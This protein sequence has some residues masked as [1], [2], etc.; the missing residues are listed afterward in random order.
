M[1]SVHFMAALL[2]AV[3]LL[4]A[5]IAR[6]EDRLN[7]VA[8]EN[9]YGDLARQIGGSH[10]AVTSILNNPDEDP[11]LFEASPSTA[12]A[13]PTRRSS[14]TTAPT[15]IRGWTSCSRHRS[16]RDRTTIVV[17][18][19]V[20]KKSGDNPH[21]WYDPATMPAVAKALAADLS[22]ARSRQRGDYDARLATFL[23]SLKAIDNESP[24]QQHYAGT[25]VTA[26]EPVFGY[27]AEALGFKM[28]NE[29]F[30]LAVMNDT[31]PSAADIAAFEKEP[32]G[33]RGQ[34]LDLQSARL[35]TSATK[36]L[37]ELAK[38]RQGHRHRRHRDR[39]RRPDLSRLVQRPARRAVERA[40][41]RTH[42]RRRIRAGDADARA[43]AAFFPTSPFPLRDGEFVGLLGPTAPAR[44]R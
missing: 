12:R 1:R 19:L 34:V 3:P 8:A 11:H 23:A 17:A 4:T 41:D 13:M 40:A 25:P 33:R 27:M 2:V 28:L 14:S 24:G 16:G 15:T 39:A 10:V 32:E 21:L 35:P 22:Q 37:L 6:A 36:R 38:A 42:E 31:E 5:N 9:F 29:R 43:G 18:E 7:I 20:G 26:T 30:Q 44:R